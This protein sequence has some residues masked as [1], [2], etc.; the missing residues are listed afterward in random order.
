MANHLCG[1]P[2]PRRFDKF[3][4]AFASMN[5]P[6]FNGPSQS[7]SGR[8]PPSRIDASIANRP[9][10][11]APPNTSMSSNT[12]SVTPSTGGNG[13]KSPFRMPPR[14]ATAPLPYRVPS[15]E[16]PLPQD[17]AFPVFPTTK[18]R[19]ATPT[20]PSASKQSFESTAPRSHADGNGIMAPMSA[21]NNVGGFLQRM[22]TITPGPFNNNGDIAGDPQSILTQH[23]ARRSVEEEAQPPSAG[24]LKTEFQRPSTSG[25]DHIKKTSFSSVSSGSRSAVLTRAK[26]HG[27]P[28]P[29]DS[30]P[31]RAFRTDAEMGPPPV[32]ELIMKNPPLD[33]FRQGNKSQPFSQQAQNYHNGAEPTEW[34]S[35]NA[36]ESAALNHKRQASVAAAN[37]PLYEIGSTSTYRPHRTTPSQSTIPIRIETG[38]EAPRSSSRSGERTDARL[39][40]VPPVPAPTRAEDFNIGNPYHTPTESVSSNGSAR[41]DI[42][43][44]SSRS[45]PPLSETSHLSGS[46]FLDDVTH[47]NGVLKD[48]QPTVVAPAF[49]HEIPPT[50]RR[51]TKSF[52]RPTYARPVL[53]IPPP[54]S[55]TTPPES[56]MDP[57]VQSSR[58]TPLSPPDSQYPPSRPVLDARS[59]SSQSQSSNTTAKRE[60]KHEIFAVH[61]L[62]HLVTT[63]SSPR[64]RPVEP[65]P[66]ELPINASD[67]QVPAP[68]FLREQGAS[69]PVRRPGTANKGNCR[70]CGELIQGK[71]VSSADGR[72]TGRYHKQCFV[73]QTCKEPFQT[74][75][76]YV[77]DNNP[78]CARHYHELN[79]SLCKTCDRGIEG[80]YLET[81]VKQKFHPHC[82][83]CQECHKI[84]RND[85]F[86]LNGK[87]FCEQHALN[88]S[89]IHIDTIMASAPLTIASLAEMRPLF[90]SALIFPLALLLFLLISTFLIAFCYCLL[91][92]LRIQRHRYRT[93]QST[94]D[95]YDMEVYDE[96]NSE[97]ETEDDSMI[98]SRQ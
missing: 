16:L 75:D 68:P 86:E 92:F 64:V 6:A 71:S 91:L 56:P 83:T 97:N 43:S 49:E 57:A 52:S 28:M 87:I 3:N 74:T 46:K 73:C 84:L 15:P 85:Y 25:S 82:F 89:Q 4:N 2:P 39:H 95:I 70:G 31:P 45:S 40:S 88:A 60:A 30:L 36:S 14:S 93:Q 41:S 12:R 10:S 59:H 37:R 96:D 7:R 11:P 50:K 32:P 72:L 19:N 76:F 98:R 65:T 78:Y 44:G 63:P 79:G 53:Q 22:N 13:R 42:H 26:S 55:E 23:T 81:E 94:D 8:M 35:K 34:A 77:I 18:S 51:P 54:G 62:Q 38:S 69:S 29:S 80:Q 1:Q 58:F 24:Y 33:Y 66:V 9:Y 27:S 48:A 61:P 20:T 21:R 90:V 5:A 67:M 47:I 17:C